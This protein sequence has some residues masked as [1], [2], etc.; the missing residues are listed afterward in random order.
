M[1]FW[2][3]LMLDNFFLDFLKSNNYGWYYDKKHPFFGEHILELHYM[4][5]DAQLIFFQTN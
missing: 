4:D 2:K 1:K 3:P 5:T